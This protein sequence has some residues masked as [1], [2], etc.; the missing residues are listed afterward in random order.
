MAAIVET[1]VPT[2][3]TLSSP[4]RVIISDT[5]KIMPLP[6]DILLQVC[7][8]LGNQLDF[9]T[10][11]N[12]A[13][14]G[15]QLAGSALLWLYRWVSCDGTLNRILTICRIHNEY[16]RI[17][18]SEGDAPEWAETQKR[19]SR[20]SPVS[21]WALL[22]KSVIRSSLG[23]T[24][25]PYCLYI[26][27][28]D[29]SNLALLLDDSAFRTSTVDDF[30][31]DEMAEFLSI[32]GTPHRRSKRNGRA[33]VRLNVEIVLNLIG[34]SIT[35]YVSER[36]DANHT[37]VALEQLSGDITSVAL[38]IWV[39]RLSRLRSM[40]I[41]DG[42]ALNE[43][44][45]NAILHQCPNFEEVRIWM[46][47]D[48]TD[49]IPAS[50]LEGLKPNSL[51]SV[52]VLSHCKVGPAFLVALNHHSKSLKN[53][54]LL[55]LQ[56]EAIR[57]LNLLQECTSL[58]V[59]DIEDAE[60]VVDLEATENDVFLEVIEWLGRCD[61][62]RELAMKKVVSAP[63]ILTQV[64]LHNNIRLTR[65][66]VH[67]N[68]LVTSPE[69][70]RALSHQ[71][72]LEDLALRGSSDDVFRTRD[73]IDNVVS[74][75]SHLTKLK[76]LTLAESFEYFSSSEIKHLAHKLPLL[77]KFDFSGYGVGDEILPYLAS[78][79][80]LRD[81]NIAAVTSF[82]RDGLLKYISTLQDT[83]QGLQLSVLCQNADFDLGGLQ[84]QFIREAISA[85][86]G[87]RFDYQLLREAAESEFDS[88]SD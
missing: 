11:F 68:T 21:R 87:G 6:A 15:R 83:N 66:E 39:G 86:V 45:A 82:T 44:V 29:L 52:E 75:I 20:S 13:V 69:F 74:C 38:P 70:Y 43:N 3:A 8:E 10:L 81:L 19:N 42:K 31:A 84:E 40:T 78:L 37:T 62:L 58:E 46:C 77:E 48:D 22:W 25:H 73:E 53:L 16:L 79:H 4:G 47:G 60:R 24:S 35:R 85:K 17:V 18:S 27:S 2:P 61:K 51:V 30:F 49:R 34:E 88:A 9:G 5:H 32:D 63:A 59:L 76:E 26:R 1:N 41:W 64:C 33:P 72:D 80:H 55:S 28:L 50:F 54:K 71:T 56:T 67:S 36:A 14:S 12:C 23:A 57:N 65:L 7:E